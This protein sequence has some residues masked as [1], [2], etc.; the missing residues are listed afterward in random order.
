MESTYDVLYKII[1]DSWTAVGN[2]EIY[3]YIFN[4]FYSRKTNLVN[5]FNDGSFETESC[6]T[7]GVEFSTKIIEEEGKRIKLQ[8]WDSSSLETFNSISRVY[9]RGSNGIIFVYDITTLY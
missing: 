3:I 6:T 4:C 1:L 9:Y 5:R 7:V 2:R 8:I